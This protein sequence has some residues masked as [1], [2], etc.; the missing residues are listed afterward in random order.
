MSHLSTR[1]VPLDSTSAALLAERGLRAEVVDNDGPGF[2]AFLG[3]ISRG[4]LDAAP[5]PEQIADSRAG[6]PSRRLTGVFDDAATHPATP[7]GTIDSWIT[8]LTTSPGRTLPMWA[9]SGVT[10]AP[11]HRRRGIATAML[12]GELRAAADAGLALAGLTVTEATIYGR[13]GF[14]PAASTADWE[15]DAHRARWIGP[16]PTG[17][18]DF[19]EQNDIPA[20]LGEVR[21]RVRMQRPGEADGWPALWRRQAG[22]RPG[23]TEAASVRAV[24]YR[25]GGGVDGI[26]VYTI[27]ENADDYHAGATFS[28]RILAAATDDATAALWRFALEHDLVGRITATLQELDSP[29]P[30]MLSD[31]RAL[32]A[33]VTDHH[34]LRVLDVPATLAARTFAAE[35]SLTIGIHDPLGFADG[36]WHVEIDAEGSAVVE[37]STAEPDV[38]MSVNALG[39]LYLGGTRAT[40]LRTA[41][42][43]HGQD[44]AVRTLDTAFAPARTPVLG[45]WY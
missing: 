6:M 30:F 7:V 16:T 25:D 26:L 21:D 35:A 24:A 13:W 19:V 45:I 39:A 40:T 20:I 17:R 37:A 43:L 27:A 8:E 4:F 29:V 28:V 23:A 12:T 10:V 11:T 44:A 32:R 2:D 34:W 33:R 15:I 41:G 36:G 1:S 38:T 9:I 14:A 42:L 18:L 3:A 31:R 22:L 5:T